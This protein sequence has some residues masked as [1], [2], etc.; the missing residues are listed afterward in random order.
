MLKSLKG[1]A[2]CRIR[3]SPSLP[4]PLPPLVETELTMEN[5]HGKL[6]FTK[7]STRVY[8]NRSLAATQQTF[9][10]LQ[11][12]SW[13]RLQRVFSVTIFRLPRRLQHVLKTSWKR[14]EDISQ[15]VFKTSWKKKIVTLKTS[16]RRFE[17]M[18][19]SCLEDMSWRRL[20]DISWRRLEDISWG[21]L[22]DVL[23]T[24]K[25]KYVY[26]WSS[27]CTFNKSISDKSKANPKCID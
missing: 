3:R 18:S 24:N 25:S 6:C 7:F 16:W 12:I 1:G 9:V 20:E 23:E 22:Q 13:R 11:D 26:L 5:S 4:P 10:G 19:W 21:R 14:F 15:N 2:E 27:K 17:D 8:W